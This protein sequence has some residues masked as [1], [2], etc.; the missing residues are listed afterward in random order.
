MMPAIE[1]AARAQRRRRRGHGPRRR[2]R[3]H[4]RERLRPR[5]AP[6]RDARRER[7]RGR[8]APRARC[9]CTTACSTSSPDSVYAGGLRNNRDFLLPR[10]HEEGPAGA[11]EHFAA[12]SGPAAQGAAGRR[13]SAGTQAGRPAGS[14]ARSPSRSRASSPSSTRRPPAACSWPSRPRSTCCCSTRSSTPAPA[15]G[16][17]VRSSPARPARSCSRADAVPDGHEKRRPAATTAASTPSPW[18]RTTRRARPARRVRRADI[19]APRALRRPVPAR[20]RRSGSSPS[21]AGCSSSCSGSAP[22]SPSGRRCR[23]SPRRNCVWQLFLAVVIGVVPVLVTLARLVGD[24]ARLPRGRGPAVLDDDPGGV[25]SRR[26]R[27]RVRASR[28]GR[29][30]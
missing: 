2:A 25:G 9:R 28:R 4:R 26:H 12:A 17:S 15:P 23:A 3:L 5:R 29:T 7:G 20:G 30:G 22:A 16:R 19:V 24:R 11:A 13:R 1:E 27:A 10:L 18:R 21:S 14:P 6:R 8:R